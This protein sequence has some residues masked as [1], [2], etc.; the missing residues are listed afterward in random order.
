MC[1]KARANPPLPVKP[2]PSSGCCFCHE[3]VQLLRYWYRVGRIQLVSS[4]SGGHRG[5]SKDKE[6]G[7]RW[8]WWG[9]ATFECMVPWPSLKCGGWGGLSKKERSKGLTLACLLG[10]FVFEL[11]FLLIL[12]DP[13]LISEEMVLEHSVLRDPHLEF[14][15]SEDLP[16][17]KK[18]TNFLYLFL[19]MAMTLLN[20]RTTK[21]K[22]SLSGFRRRP[23]LRILTKFHL[24]NQT[25]YEG[26][27]MF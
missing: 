16:L 10:P 25:F 21:L 13:L 22:G 8:W 11:H 23:L 3:E 7:C 2:L 15:F 19:F 12:K 6:H 14:G 9:G 4:I 17:I 5:R 1:N 24:C 27:I 18:N 26:T 20:W